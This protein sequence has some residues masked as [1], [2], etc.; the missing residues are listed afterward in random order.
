MF[1]V[2][3]SSCRPTAY[4]FWFGLVFPFLLIYLLNWIIFVLIMV[5]LIKK[6]STEQEHKKLAV[7]A[8][9]LSIVFGLGW[10]LGLAAT[11]S[12]VEEVTFTF[13]VIFSIFVGSQGLLIFIFH[14]IRS[15]I[16][17]KE[18]AH[19]WKKLP[20]VKRMRSRRYPVSTSNQAPGYKVFN[21]TN[22][23]LIMNGSL[24]K[25]ITNNKNVE[26]IKNEHA[27]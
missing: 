10:G 5:S 13:Q 24:D 23:D 27:A 7:I 11:S 2:L 16:V 1:F 26:M 12:D 8:I 25:N 14:G 21:Q 9:G 17:R 22:S 3:A 19:Q 4:P 6:R 15:E 20:C 18:W